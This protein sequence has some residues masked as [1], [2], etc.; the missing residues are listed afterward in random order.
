MLQKELQSCSIAVEPVLFLIAAFIDPFVILGDQSVHFPDLKEPRLIILFDHFPGL[1]IDPDEYFIRTLP[2]CHVV[3]LI[4]F[5]ADLVCDI[6]CIFEAIDAHLVEVL[7][8]EE[9]FRI[10]EIIAVPAIVYS[11]LLHEFDFQTEVCSYVL[12]I[13]ITVLKGILYPH[14]PEHVA[15]DLYHALTGDR[16]PTVCRF[17]NYRSQKDIK[18]LRIA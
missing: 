3:D 8:R 14:D 13:F 16:L 7:R 15:T 5:G 6:G 12:D 17:W 4:V 2:Q 11:V 9:C 18:V 1:L 10:L